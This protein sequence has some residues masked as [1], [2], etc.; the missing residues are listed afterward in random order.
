[1]GL[2]GTK[3]WYTL[4]LAFMCFA[5]FGSE[6]SSGGEVALGRALFFDTRLSEP[7]G[8]SCASCHQPQYAYAHK[9]QYT[10]V[11][12]DEVTYGSRNTPSIVY[13]A[14]APAFHF[15]QA[16]QRYR[17]GMSWSGK[18]DTL[19]TQ[20]AS[21]IT[22]ALE[23]ANDDMQGWYAKVFRYHF[24]DLLALGAGEKDWER[25]SKVALGAMSAFMQ[26]EALASRFSSK[27]D[28]S[29]AGNV[30]L[31]AQERR[32]QALFDGK[33]RCSG[34]HTSSGTDDVPA[35]FTD[36]SYANVGIPKQHKNL[37]YYLPKAYNPQGR[38]FVD[39]GLADNPRVSESAD[40]QGLFRVPSLRNVAL[41]PP[42]MHNGAFESLYDAVAFHAN[43]SFLADLPAPETRQNLSTRH[44]PEARLSRQELSDLVAFL[45][46]LT[47]ASESP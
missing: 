26:S 20:S 40:L 33:G 12:A 9:D 31:S 28:Q 10:S 6:P 34:C 21:A 17:G 11:S 45:H 32:G 46:T 27:F 8:Q 41:T 38:K 22:Q 18:F 19:E 39:P 1:M 29:L 15:D 43:R 14:Y 3:V 7:Q 2:P 35:L 4:A 36:F 42:Y 16:T 13:S 37:F 30:T 5:A 25:G 24:A 47:D 44:Q 23:M